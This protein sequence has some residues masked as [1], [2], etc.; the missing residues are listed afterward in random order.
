MQQNSGLQ[1]QPSAGSFAPQNMWNGN[2]GG[3]GG[4]PT[5]ENTPQSSM[6]A[7]SPNFSNLGGGNNTAAVMNNRIP[8]QP[9]QQEM[10]IV[11]ELIQIK[12][13]MQN[14]LNFQAQNPFVMNFHNSSAP[15]FMMRFSSTGQGKPR[16]ITCNSASETLLGADSFKAQSSPLFS[17][18]YGFG[19]DPSDQDTRE[20]I[21]L[22]Q[23][24][25]SLNCDEGSRTVRI[26]NSFFKETFVVK[27]RIFYATYAP[28]RAWSDGLELFSR[29]TPLLSV[30][31]SVFASSEEL[32]ED[33]VKKSVGR[34]YLRIYNLQQQMI[35]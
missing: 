9:S 30:T 1:Q 35:S 27:D 24:F 31:P 3:G 23:Q 2:M 33:T 25:M 19:M 4:Q 29:R 14:M 10:S 8:Q 32:T 11:N 15:S 6:T 26:C 28:V 13:Q 34:I 16:I 21:H 5:S 22:I 17:E 12:H 20:H 7:F 18:Y